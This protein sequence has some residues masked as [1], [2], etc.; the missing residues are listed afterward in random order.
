MYFDF[1]GIENIPQKSLNQIKGNQSF[2]T[3]LEYNLMIQVFMDFVALL[4]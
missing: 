2:A 1:F 4:S 3:Y